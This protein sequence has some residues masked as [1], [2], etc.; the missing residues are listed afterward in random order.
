[1]DEDLSKNDGSTENKQCNASAAS[2][3]DAH[4]Q[5]PFGNLEILKQLVDIM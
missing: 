4:E 2:I 5:K 1:M 3:Y